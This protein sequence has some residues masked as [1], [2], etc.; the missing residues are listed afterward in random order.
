MSFNN[1]GFVTHFT[2][3]QVSLR[4]QGN[5]VVTNNEY[6]YLFIFYI[7][8]VLSIITTRIGNFNYF[9]KI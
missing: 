7:H 9:I 1:S 2:Y 5:Y 6:K 3:R 8:P 4:L